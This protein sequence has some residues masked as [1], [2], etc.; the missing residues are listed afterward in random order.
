MP[1]LE[2]SAVT[3]NSET[4]ARVLDELELAKAA[5]T[6]RAYWISMQ[7]PERAS[8]FDNWI[9]A[10]RQLFQVP[11]C[12]VIRENG[13]ICLRAAVPGLEAKDLRLTAL[14]EAIVIA[15]TEAAEPEANGADVVFSEMNRN[16]IL[17]RV[18]LPERINLS[19]VK[20]RL[21]R[22]ILEVAAAREAIEPT[23][24]SPRRAAA[25]RNGSAAKAPKKAAGAGKTAR[26][27]A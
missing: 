9:E 27:K 13:D 1:K 25:A 22:G 17:R 2:V 19:S 12:E 24:P 11:S 5:I 26:P 18:S 3:E 20:A 14:P 4:A 23:K 16:R 21:E 7:R 6:E 8:E 15:S 10:E